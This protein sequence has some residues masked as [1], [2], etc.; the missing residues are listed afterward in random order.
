[1]SMKLYK[2]EI[3]EY[4][5]GSRDLLRIEYIATDKTPEDLIDDLPDHSTILL[6]GDLKVV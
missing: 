2:V 6:L 4:L 3:R 1:M 5:A